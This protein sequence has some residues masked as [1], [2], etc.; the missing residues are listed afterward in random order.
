MAMIWEKVQD[1]WEMA[2]MEVNGRPVQ[3]RVLW[4]KNRAAAS[5]ARGDLHRLVT[6][7]FEHKVSVGTASM[8]DVVRMTVG[9]LSEETET[10][11]FGLSLLI[12]MERNGNDDR[13]LEWG[14][15]A[16][17]KNTALRIASYSLYVKAFG[18]YGST[19]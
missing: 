8:G 4:S 3:P 17:S 16:P 14:C 7:R 2:L 1:E 9:S 5:A 19:G 18:S 12:I 13:Y 11:W 6:N 10:H 15:F